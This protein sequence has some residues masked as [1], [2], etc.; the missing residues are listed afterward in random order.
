MPTID[1]LRKVRL[2]KLAI[3]KKKGLDPYPAD[4]SRDHTI[5]EAR[6]A[7]GKTVVIVGRVMSLRGHGKIVFGDV[8]DV[9]GKIQIVFKEDILDKGSQAVLELLDIGD[10]VECKG[11]VGATEAGEISVFALSL[12]II[13]KAVRPLPDVWHGL[14]DVEERYRQRYVDLVVNPGIRELFVTRTKVVQFL[15]SFLDKDGFLEVETPVLQPLYGGA[16][17]K[18]FVTHHNS[19]HPHFFFPNFH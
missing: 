6:S 12:R 2:D 13:A 8:V 17:A 4:V 11:E 14:K 10:F 16:S 19:L 9:S 1:E 18:P 5:A 3:L 7:K 15:R